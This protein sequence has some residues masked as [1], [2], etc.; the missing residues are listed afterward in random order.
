MNICFLPVGYAALKKRYQL[1]ICQ[2]LS[3]VA[4]GF[5]AQV[6]IKGYN[7]HV[8]VMDLLATHTNNLITPLFVNVHNFLVFYKEAAKLTFVPIPTVTHSLSG[9]IDQVNGTAQEARGQDKPAAASADQAAMILLSKIT[10][11]KAAVAQ[12]I[13]QKDLACAIAEQATGIAEEVLQ[14]CVRAKEFLDKALRRQ[15]TLIDQV[16][17]AAAVKELEM[18]EVTY[19]KKE[20]SATAKGNIAY[21]ANAFAKRACNDFY[22][23]TR[24][25][26]ALCQQQAVPAANQGQASPMVNGPPAKTES[27]TSPPV[28]A[29]AVF[30]LGT[31]GTILPNNPYVRASFLLH[32]ETTV[33]LHDTMAPPQD[34][35]MGNI[36]SD[37]ATIIG[38]WTVVLAAMKTLMEQGIIGP[39]QQFH[40][41]I[42]RN[43]QEQHIAKGTLK[44]CLTSA[45]KRI[46][47]VVDIEC[48]ASRPTLKGLIPED[49]DKMT[50]DLKGR[51][52]LLKAKL[53]KRAKYVKGDGKT[54]KK[55]KGKAVAK[56]NTKPAMVT[57]SWS[58]EKKKESKRK[59]QSTKKKVARNPPAAKS[60][61][62]NANAAKSKT[63]PS[64]NKIAWEKSREE[65]CRSQVMQAMEWR[66]EK[67]HGFLPAL[68]L[69]THLNARQVL[70]NTSPGC[71]FLRASNS[72]FHDLKNNHSLPPTAA[73]LLELGLKFIPTPGLSPAAEEIAP[74]LDCIERDIG[75][76]TYFSSRDEGK[77]SKLRA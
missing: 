39:L 63:P 17:I 61:G 69:S 19:S 37:A 53:N 35:V 68:T 12:A 30:T 44:P 43:Q 15:A 21:G 6:G 16:E 2:L 29:T 28:A 36:E 20:H 65:N 75:L 8:A 56:K 50:D 14:Q 41:C 45:A 55:K 23:A 13:T 9:V 24:V 60:K 73:S 33:A 49:V 76:K 38:G 3:M 42:T 51:I 64:K 71:Y 66:V 47:A 70:G 48:P 10:A 25:L 58:P 46:A 31:N 67:S 62:T 77:Y 26:N 74:S 34:E 54:S 40:A 18:A 57:S 32:N 52:Q 11:A 59:E 72:T 4:K 27:H 7:T 5:I 1:S 22:A